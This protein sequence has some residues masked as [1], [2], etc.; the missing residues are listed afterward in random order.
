MQPPRP[1]GIINFPI[2]EI[3]NLQS[4]YMPFVLGG[5]LFIPSNR[6]VVLGDDVFVVTSLPESSERIPLTGKV[7][8][9]SHRA[10]GTRPAGFAIQL[11]GEEG[12]KFKNAAEKLLVGKLSSANPTFTL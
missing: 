12:I 9:I 7:I 6:P 1:G 5:G 3:S 8:W 11:L 10:S 4:C 2:R